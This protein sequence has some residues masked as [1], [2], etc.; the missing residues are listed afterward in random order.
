[1]Q[2]LTIQKFN[3]ICDEVFSTSPDIVCLSETWLKSSDS[4]S[5]EV[6]GYACIN[7]PR[8]QIHRNAKR[9]SGGILLYI[10]EGIHNDVVIMNDTYADDRIW[11]KLFAL[12][13]YEDWNDNILLLL[14][15]ASK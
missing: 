2:G 8:S 4:S 6:Q 9:G 10:K 11:I 7:K 15:H 5:F 13:K 12:T 14:L 3:S 1:M